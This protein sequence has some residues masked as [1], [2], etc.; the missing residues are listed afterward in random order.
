MSKH[1]HASRAAESGLVA[2]ELAELGITGP[3]S[4]LE[5][6]KGFY[7]ATCPDASP[8]AVT[9]SPEA[10]WQLLQCSSS[11][12]RPVVIPIQQLMLH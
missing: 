9:A 11:A 5:G 2:A 6:E 3:R 7:A 4:I 12:G 1:L 8:E 10:D